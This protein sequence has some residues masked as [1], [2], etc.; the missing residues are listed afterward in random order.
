VN[1]SRGG[2]YYANLPDIGDRPV[3]VVSWDPISNGMDSPI[4][5]LITATDRIRAFETHV[6]VEAR[7]TGLDY[8]SYILCHEL[9]TL[10]RADFRRHVGNV[11][12][13]T[14]IKTELALKRA[15]DLP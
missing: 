5:C 4:V 15:L 12:V 3:L 8:D 6:H 11:S 7:E 9:A 1:V 14:L 2:V 13:P 10:D